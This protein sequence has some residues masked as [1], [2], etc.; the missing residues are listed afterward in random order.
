MSAITSG[1][2]IFR[3]LSCA[4]AVFTALGSL[5][6][7]TRDGWP[8]FVIAAQTGKPITIY[9]DGKQ[10]RDVLFVEDLL[11]AYDAAL[12]RLDVTAGKVYNVGGGS[13]KTLSVWKQFGPILEELAGRK[14]ETRWGDWR[15]GDQ[16]IYISDIRKAQKELGLEPEGQPAGRY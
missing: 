15:P 10:V 6:L 1:F 12:S 11:D 7:K 4:R 2:M 16:R 3:R 5:G 14:I 9:G 8:W 13:D